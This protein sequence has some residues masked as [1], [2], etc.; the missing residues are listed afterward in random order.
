MYPTFNVL[1]GL[2]FLVLGSS[3]WGM[4]YVFAVDFWALALLVQL[5]LELGPVCFGLMWTVA[6]VT[7]GQRL[8]RLGQETSFQGRKAA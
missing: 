1:S 7:I 5:R 3:Y 2:I 6:L 8:C 4:C